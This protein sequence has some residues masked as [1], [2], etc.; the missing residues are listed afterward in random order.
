MAA[1]GGV[2]GSQS[3]AWIKAPRTIRG[4]TTPRGADRSTGRM[5]FTA[6]RIS[7]GRPRTKD[8]PTPRFAGIPRRLA[9]D[10]RL[11]CREVDQPEGGFQHDRTTDA[12]DR[13]RT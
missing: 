9:D 10:R 6:S 5:E 2:A 13:S 11:R 7:D 1:T 8:R 3:V 4:M 12:V